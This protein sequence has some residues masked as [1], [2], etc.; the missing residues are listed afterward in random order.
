MQRS[1]F[2]YQ[3]LDISH[4]NHHIT[5]PDGNLLKVMNQ[6]DIIFN[7]GFTL[8]KVLYVPK[9]QF[10]LN[11]A[12]KLYMDNNCSLIFTATS[13]GIQ[14]PTT[15]RLLPLGEYT[16]GLY[17]LL[18]KRVSTSPCAAFINNISKTT[19]ACSNSML[20]Q[21]K[22]LHLRQGHAPFDKNQIDVLE[23]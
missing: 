10:N 12:S 1:C 19:L 9:L 11:F 3:Y 6:G 21:A 5:I 20:Q 13:C 2:H 4:S 15:K 17:Y 22:L 14:D 16:K 18:D 7:D 8:S 23:Y